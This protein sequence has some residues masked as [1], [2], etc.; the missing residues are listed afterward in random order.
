MNFPETVRMQFR[1][2]ACCYGAEPP[3]T[4]NVD[5]SDFY[6]KLHH[7][8][9]PKRIRGLECVPVPDSSPALLRCAGY[10]CSKCGEIIF[11]PEAA[12]IFKALEHS[13]CSGASRFLHPDT[14]V[15]FVAKRIIERLFPLYF[16]SMVV[17][18]PQHDGLMRQWEAIITE[19]IERAR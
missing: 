18:G 15:G 5:D 19:E 2:V 7:F 10:E 8:L 4:I 14:P 11:L 16:G 1:R 17:R 6:M 12:D 13:P 9:T 3:K